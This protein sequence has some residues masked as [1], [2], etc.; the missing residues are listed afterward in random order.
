MTEYI[1]TQLSDRPDLI[2]KVV[3]DYP[4]YGKRLLLDNGWYQALR[5]DNVRLVSDAIQRMTADGLTTAAGHDQVDVIVFATGFDAN[6]VLWPI[7]ITG[8]DSTNVRQ[9]LDER[10]EAYRGMAIKDCPNL[11]VTPGP[12]GT[13]GHGG[14]GIFFAECQ[15]DYI[16]GCL[17][18]MC[19][20][21]WRK[22]EVRG[23]AVQAYIDETSREL[24]HY[25]WSMPGISNWFRGSRDR[26]TAIVPKR[27]IDMWQEGKQPDLSAYITG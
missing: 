24:E 19:D 3:P 4:P 1:R 8:Q 26:V 13:P 15:I 6:Q 17:R 16:L 10:P 23:A 14:S 27:L 12:N 5:R 11:F 2:A 7:K 20:H 22:L 18:A 25:V 9:R 21:G